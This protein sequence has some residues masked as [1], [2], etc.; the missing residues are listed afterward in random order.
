M[1]H[2]N[3]SYKIIILWYGNFEVENENKSLIGV[4][5][6]IVKNMIKEIQTIG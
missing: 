6:T 1:R 2:I 3:N 4:Y 5:R